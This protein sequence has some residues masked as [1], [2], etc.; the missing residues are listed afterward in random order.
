[1]SV[2]NNRK[3]EKIE[4]V[5]NECGLGGGMCIP[6]PKA[7]EFTVYGEN[8][9]GYTKAARA[10]LKERKLPFSYHTLGKQR[11]EFAR[12]H[13]NDH[14]TIPIVFH[15]RQFIGGNSDLQSMLASN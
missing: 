11:A 7:K 14:K 15:N 13:A 2:G 6:L 1:M 12:K 5:L 3:Q 9:C 10:S 4:K 8:Y